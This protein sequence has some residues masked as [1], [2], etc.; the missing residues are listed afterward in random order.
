[1]SVLWHRISLCDASR[2][3]E[4]GWNGYETGVQVSDEESAALTL[5]RH[6]FHRDWNYSLTTTANARSKSPQAITD[7]PR[8]NLDFHGHFVVAYD[9]LS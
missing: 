2:K 4:W 8:T 5:T 9:E 1:L 6:K 7:R 3:V